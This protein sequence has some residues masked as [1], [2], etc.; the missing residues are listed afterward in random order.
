MVEGLEVIGNIEKKIRRIEMWEIF[1]MK[2]IGEMEEFIWENKVDIGESEESIR[3]EK[4]GEDGEE[5]G[6]KRIGKNE[7]LNKEGR[8][9]RD[10]EEEEIFKIIKIDIVRV[11]MRIEVFKKRKKMIIGRIWRIIVEEIE[12]IEE[13]EVEIVEKIV[14]K[15]KMERVKGIRKKIGKSGFK[16]I[17]RKVDGSLVVERK[18]EERN[19]GNEGGILDNRR[20]EELKKNVVGLRNIEK[21][22]KVEVE[23]ESIVEED[24]SIIDRKE[25]IEW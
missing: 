12:I 20:R 25:I 2:I 5:I 7:L 14:K 24:R 22:E 18:R 9:K 10:G 21:K 23:E 3:R 15:L 6:L 8:L 13:I 19:K 4:E 17:M 16:D 11:M 1:I